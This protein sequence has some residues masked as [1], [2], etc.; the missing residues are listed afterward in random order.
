VRPRSVSAFIFQQK[1]G[2]AADHCKRRPELMAHVLREGL[3]PVAHL[4]ERIQKPVE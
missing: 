4:V 3:F 1:L 2:G